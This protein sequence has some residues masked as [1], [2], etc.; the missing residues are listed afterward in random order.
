M[1]YATQTEFE[2]W[3]QRHFQSAPHGRFLGVVHWDGI[4]LK[5]AW[6]DRDP[7]VGHAHEPNGVL[8]A[9]AIV[10]FGA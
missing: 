4:N 8:A 9:A 3:L 10:A 2:P 6:Q 7:L 5:I 1:P